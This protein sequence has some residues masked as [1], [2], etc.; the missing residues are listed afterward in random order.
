MLNY[1]VDLE[2]S[3]SKR[4]KRIANLRPESLSNARSRVGP[5]QNLRRQRRQPIG[6]LHLPRLVSRSFT[7]IWK[8]L[9]LLEVLNNRHQDLIGEGPMP[10]SCKFQDRNFDG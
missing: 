7:P 2:M 9:V 1:V 5:H 4:I 8:T 10:R 3:D 6:W